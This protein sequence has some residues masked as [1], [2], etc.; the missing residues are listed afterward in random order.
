M[1]RLFPLGDIV[2]LLPQ[3]QFVCGQKRE[4]LVDSVFR[5]ENLENAWQEICAR[6]GIP[7]KTLAKLN[8]SLRIVKERVTKEVLSLVRNA[9]ARDFEIFGYTPP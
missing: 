1:R 9:Y 3:H 6:I 2:H 5:F 7:Q 4:I 8:P